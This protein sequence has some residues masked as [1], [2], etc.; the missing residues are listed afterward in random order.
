MPQMIIEVVADS[1]KLTR[2]LKEASSATKKFDK[3]L[4]TA[5][6]GVISGTGIMHSFGRTLA[7]ASGG[8]IAFHTGTELIKSSIDAAR[9][10]VTAQKSLAVQMAAAGENFVKNREQ[11]DKLAESYSKFGF[12]NDEVVQSL[13][14]LERGTGSINKA[15][16][17]QQLTADIARA[18]NLGLAASAQVVA[19]VFGGQETALRRAV[20]GLEKNAHGWD[21]IREAQQKMRGQAEANTTASEKFAATLH[22]TEEIIGSALLPVID[23]YLSAGARWL[24]QLNDSGR[25]QRYAARFATGFANALDSVWRLL[26]PLI[27]GFQELAGVLGGFGNTITVLIGAWAGFKAAGIASA[28]AVSTANVVAAGITEKAWQ[29]ALISTGWG[30]FAVA[31]GVAASYVITHWEKVKAWFQEFWAFLK[32][33]AVDTLKF[34][35]EPFSHLPG[36]LGQW[37]RDLKK[38]LNLK[39]SGFYKQFSEAQEQAAKAGKHT[40]KAYTDDFD[41]W[42]KNW[43]KQHP[44]TDPTTSVKAKTGGLTAN[45]RAQQ[46]NTWFDNMIGRQ[47]DR[48]QDLSL[49]KQLAQLKVIYAEVAARLSI[50]HDAT[51][52]LTLRD[53]LVQILREERSV[54]G[55][56]TDEMKQQNQALKDRADAIKQAVLGRLDEREQRIQNKR[57]FADAMQQLKLAQQIG[58]PEGIKQA[59][60]NVHDARFAIYRAALESATPRLTRG[61]HGGQTFSLG[62]TITINIHGTDSPEAVA[63]KVVAIIQRHGRHTTSQQRGPTSGAAGPH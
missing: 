21:L 35:V 4:S 20:P 7:F 12:D 50:T 17:L 61:A 5:F 30:I 8:F 56:I 62:N 27:R 29:A 44:I 15:M 37:A 33:T 13:T 53:K 46:R 16:R 25:L 10:A 34:I 9:E 58:G 14:V 22:N 55:Q 48:V 45:Q 47:L 31:A 19:K 51:R 24:Q 3:E 42:W 26:R 1:R 63:R 2:G 11:I 54:Q 57:A 18:K 23:R 60:R 41:K 6:R 40:A 36:K 59:L 49:K 38:S 28:I 32:F 39:E 52:Q 43:L